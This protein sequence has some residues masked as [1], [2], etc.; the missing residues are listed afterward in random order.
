MMI[1]LILSLHIALIGGHQLTCRPK[2]NLNRTDFDH[3][4]DPAS[5]LAA[6]EAETGDVNAGSSKDALKHLRHLLER[7]IE[8]QVCDIRSSRFRFEILCASTLVE[9]AGA[10]TPISKAPIN[11]M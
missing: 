2:P 8:A 5:A 3:A 4:P 1:H 7:E 11:I 6:I 10:D 9:A